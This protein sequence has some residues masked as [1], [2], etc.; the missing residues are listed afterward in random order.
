MKIEPTSSTFLNFSNYHQTSEQWK[1]Y[2][3]NRKYPTN[4]KKNDSEN[5][6]ED[7]SEIID[8]HLIGHA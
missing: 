2:F 7:S 8:E 3:Q 1:Q 4:E 5:H 6:T